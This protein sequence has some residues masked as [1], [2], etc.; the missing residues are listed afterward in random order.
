MYAIPVRVPQIRVASPPEQSTKVSLPVPTAVVAGGRKSN[1]RTVAQSKVVNVQM[2]RNDKLASIVNTLGIKTTSASRTVSE[3]QTVALATSQ[4]QN[5][6]SPPP[7]NPIVSFFGNVS[8]DITNA[9][10]SLGNAASQLAHSSN[11]AYSVIGQGIN[12]VSNAGK[13]VQNHI[14]QGVSTQLMNLKNNAGLVEN[15][16]STLADKV[17]GGSANLFNKAKSQFSSAAG[18]FVNSLGTVKNALSKLPANVQAAIGPDITAIEGKLGGLGGTIENGL[19]G[20]GTDIYN[21]LSTAYKD[22]SGAIVGAV[23][24]VYGFLK[25]IPGDLQSLGSDILNGLHGLWNDFVSFGK[26]LETEVMSGIK[27]LE[28][29]F[30][31]GVDWLWHNV[32]NDIGKFVTPYLEDIGIVLAAAVG[33]F[34]I[35]RA[36]VHHVERRAISRGVRAVGA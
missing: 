13:Y 32:E 28:N 25:T 14:A 11:P 23:N 27:L 3:K 8:N 33:I 1:A 21:G 7:S 12:D 5:A 9:G 24:H 16:V 36:E 35:G 10:K 26:W 15:G 34:L 4:V 31:K 29:D 6:K 17:A 22:A 30:M 18:K 19:K 2:L 20:V